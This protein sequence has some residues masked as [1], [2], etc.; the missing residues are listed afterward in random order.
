M[1]AEHGDALLVSYG[2]EENPRHILVDG[3][4]G[5]TFEAILAELDTVRTGDQL[6]L[7]ALVVTHYDEDH[8]VGI[9][10]IL[11]N[12]P[13]WLLISDIWFNGYR[14]LSPSD[15]LGKK[16]G[17][18]LTGLILKGKYPWNRAFDGKTIYEGVKPVLLDG[19]M[20]V[21]VL[22]PD[23]RRL[24]L[25]RAEWTNPKEFP[26]EKLQDKGDSLGKLDP[27]PPESF[28]ETADAKHGYDT[29]TPNGSSIALLLEFDDRRAL[30][31]GDA[32][33]DVVKASLS[34][35]FPNRPD[36]HLLKV[37]HHGSKANTRASLLKSMKC[38][39]FLVSTSGKKH[40]HP[41]NTLIA[42]IID[43][44]SKVEIVF[45]YDV[46][47]VSRWWRDFPSDWPKF[48]AV[49]P[50]DGETSVDLDV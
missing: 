46:E 8:I 18:I 36:I 49:Y 37:S 30:L 20:K 5:E 41:D 34:H 32:F 1:Q 7:D 15:G 50:R 38:K 4:P 22:S 3:G 31:A 25:L 26:P 39:R 27:W 6:V 12:K 9:I 13:E 23:E 35:H 47:H 14:H 43:S 45:N 33:S 10:R 42:R 16:D 2:E 48:K 40:K 24:H 17:D 21:Y 28:R 29:S 19:G 11:E 44:T